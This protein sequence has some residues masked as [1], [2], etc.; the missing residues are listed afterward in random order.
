[1]SRQYQI[2]KDG[3]VQHLPVVY[4]RTPEGRH[5]KRQC[6]F[7]YQ[8]FTKQ[9]Y[10]LEEVFYESLFVSEDYDYDV[11]YL[12]FLESYAELCEKIK[13][14]SKPKY[15]IINEF[16]WSDMFAPE[17]DVKTYSK[18]FQVERALRSALNNLVRG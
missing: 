13:S 11:L 5:F 1:M 6:E 3:S 18:S 12:A 7:E 10:E 16:Y 8:K 2:Q 17:E 9:V 14:L 4:N 15:T